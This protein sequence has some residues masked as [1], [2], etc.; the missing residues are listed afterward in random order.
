MEAVMP[1]NGFMELTEDNLMLIDAG[2]WSTHDLGVW[3]GTTA[4]AGAVEDGTVGAVGIF[5]KRS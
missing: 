4:A 1:M 3:M 2:T 5:F